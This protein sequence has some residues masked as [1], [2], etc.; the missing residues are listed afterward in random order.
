DCFRVTFDIHITSTAVLAAG[1]YLMSTRRRLPL[2]SLSVFT[3]LLV[4]ANIA[5]AQHEPASGGGIIAG[6]ST[7]TSTSRPTSTK[8]TTRP[9]KK[10]SSSTT[11]RPTT[12]STKPRTTTSSTTPVRKPTTSTSNNATAESYYQQGE[13]LYNKKN[14]KAALEL[15]PKAVAINPSM[16]L[17]PYRPGWLYNDPQA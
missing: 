4:S 16:A 15:Y 8:P 10:P 6:G 3:C 2:I 11:S 12:S 17:A 13:A 5:L 1:E 9:V 7:S 14:H